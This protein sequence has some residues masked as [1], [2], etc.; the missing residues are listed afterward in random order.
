LEIASFIN[1]TDKLGHKLIT[2]FDAVPLKLKRANKEEE[3]HRK[4]PQSSYN[5]F[6][7]VTNYDENLR[8]K[9][10]FKFHS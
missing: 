5:H 7:F 2:E 8:R 10:R 1:N 3:I 4:F 6:I 9:S